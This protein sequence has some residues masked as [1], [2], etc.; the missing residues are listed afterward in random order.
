MYADDLVLL[1][2]A[3]VGL[4]G[5]IDKLSDY[6]KVNND[7]AKIQ[8][9]SGNGQCCKT[10]FFYREKLIEDVIDYKYLGLVFSAS[11]TWSNAADKNFYA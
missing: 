6:C 11:G 4:Q 1:S 5:L 9:F 3:E 7:K 8:K 10:T 2:R